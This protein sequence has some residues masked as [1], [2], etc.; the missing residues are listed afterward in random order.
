MEH[1]WLIFEDCST[2]ALRLALKLIR[3]QMDG[4]HLCGMGLR[5]RIHVAI[6][7]VLCSALILALVIPL[8]TVH[9]GLDCPCAG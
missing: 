9:R 1:V 4:L 3:K 2:V 7:A 5:P 8:Q 6:Q